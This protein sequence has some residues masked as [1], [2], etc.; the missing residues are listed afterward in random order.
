[1]KAVA[2]VASLM[3]HGAVLAAMNRLPAR[4]KRTGTVVSMTVEQTVR[5]PPPPPPPP[6]EEVIPPPNVVP[7]RVKRRTAKNI[8]KDAPPPAAPPPPTAAP[9]PPRFAFSVDMS[10]TVQG[11]DVAVPTVEGGGNMFADPARDA[12]LPKGKGTKPAPP[13]TGS[14]KDGPPDAYQI[15]EEPRFLTPDTERAPPYPEEAKA[16]ELQGNVLL[17]VYVNEQGRVS[18]VKVLE[19]LGGGCTEAAV[20]WAK[21][22][23]RFSPAKA[24]EEPVGMWITVPVRFVLER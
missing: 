12:A 21:S 6:K 7:K 16:K 13:P 4:P 24:G 14:G 20:R 9:P 17:R 3:V 15:T 11:G 2:L 10:S 19:R 5:E 18:R 23:W 22:K 8:V 1:M